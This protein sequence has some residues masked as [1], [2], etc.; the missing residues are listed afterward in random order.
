M[1]DP[2]KLLDECNLLPLHFVCLNGNLNEVKR[3]IQ[4]I[5]IDPNQA[6]KKGNTPLHISAAYNHIEIV[7]FL[8]GLV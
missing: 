6:N 8:L 4:R 5:G 3:S 1:K 7:R 2:L